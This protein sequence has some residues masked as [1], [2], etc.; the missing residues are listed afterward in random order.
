MKALWIPIIGTI[1]GAI[2]LITYFYFKSKTKSE[3]QLTIRESLDKGA[4]LTPEL[5]E[6]LSISISPKIA[7]LRRGIVLI[8]L[9]IA[10]ILAGWIGEGA[11]EGMA[12][13]MFPLML[14]FGFLA[15]WKVNKYD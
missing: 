9:G 15:V 10:F 2:V 8:A 7:D 6:K 11:R 1:S 5:I 3:V 13:G 4:E 12:I 14:G